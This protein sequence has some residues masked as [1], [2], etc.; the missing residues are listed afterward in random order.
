MI[1]PESFEF[2]KPLFLQRFTHRPF[3]IPPPES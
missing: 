2:D 1:L 3:Q